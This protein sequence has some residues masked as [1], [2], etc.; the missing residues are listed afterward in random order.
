VITPED[1]HAFLADVLAEWAPGYT[2]A[3]EQGEQA[4]IV[5]QDADI[6]THELIFR[7][8]PARGP[9]DPRYFRA[10]VR[11]DEVKPE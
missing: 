7:V 4:R 9:G 8:E 11:L 1:F 5:L 6:F 2:D 3:D 10:S